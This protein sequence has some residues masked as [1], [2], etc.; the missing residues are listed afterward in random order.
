VSSSAS[1]NR[2]ELR[3]AVRNAIRALR[4]MPPHARERQLS[5][6]RYATFSPEEQELLRQTLAGSRG[7]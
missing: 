6:G 4:A 5:S 3:P 7:E 1:G 2:S